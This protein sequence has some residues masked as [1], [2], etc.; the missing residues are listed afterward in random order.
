MYLLTERTMLFKGQRFTHSNK[1][2]PLP[3]NM[4]NGEHHNY[5]AFGRLCHR[6]TTGAIKTGYSWQ[7][8]HT[9]SDVPEVVDDKETY[10][11]YV[12]EVK[13]DVPD[14]EDPKSGR[15]YSLTNLMY[16]ADGYAY[17]MLD[18]KCYVRKLKKS[19]D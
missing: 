10:P 7:D 12:L 4:W 1:V 15:G 6:D 8:P 5:V 9:L 11:C 19:H 17:L 14:G 13:A 16:G 2:L 3:H 18:G